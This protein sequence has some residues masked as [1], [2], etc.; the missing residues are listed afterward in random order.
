MIAFDFNW[1]EP[2]NLV[3]ILLLFLLGALQIWLLLRSAGQ[4]ISKQKVGI[5][6]VLNALLWLI[7]AGFVLQPVIRNT[8]LAGNVIIAG[9]DVPS[10]AIRNI[11][12]SL[13]IAEVFSEGN[14]KGK[15]FDTLTLVGQDFSPS[16]FADLSQKITASV[17][18]NRVPYFSDHQVQSISWSGII[19][20]GQTQRITGS[21]R[22]PDPQWVKVKFG[23]QTLDSVKL[24]KGTQSFDLSFPVFT[25]RRTNVELYLGDD[26]HETIRFFARPLPPLNFRFILDN[27]DFESRNLATWLANRGNSVEISTNL[28]K[29]IRSKVTLNKLGEP[30]VIITDPANTSNVQVKKALTAGKSIL[31]INLT[32]GSSDVSAINTALGTR[33]QVRKISNEETLPVTGELSKLPFVFVKANGYLT[34]SGYPVAV[35]KTTGKVAVSLLNET[36]PLVLNGD[37]IS[38]SSIWT[39]VVAA[40]HS[41]YRTNIEVNSPLYKGTKADLRLNNLTGNPP[42]WVLGEDTLHLDYSAVNQKTAHAAYM[43]TDSSWLTLPEDA[44]LHV[45]DRSGFEEYHKSRIVDDFV[46]A[47]LE[48]REALGESAKIS[49]LPVPHSNESRIPDWIWFLLFVL[50]FS[51]LWL[52]PKFN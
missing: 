47:R 35:E 8:V 1:L 44:E 40:I 6:I 41:A 16:F 14:L 45:S 42:L 36:F 52:E 12:D 22:S 19:R 38:Y 30:D 50:C 18:I 33:F 9:K 3:L 49:G 39:G 27:P 10:A 7:I 17:V 37:S 2:L 51:A 48:L 34:V 28:S 29:D 4:Q 13:G 24:E 26:Q 43:P 5:R 21:V 46:K 23:N 11:Q 20:K 15:S 25:E 32:N 31:F